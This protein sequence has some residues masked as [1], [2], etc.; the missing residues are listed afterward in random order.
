[1][2]NPI[3]KIEALFNDLVSKHV[4]LKETQADWL[5]KFH[6]LVPTFFKVITKDSLKHRG[7]EHKGYYWGKDITKDI[8]LQLMEDNDFFKVY[9]WFDSDKDNS[10]VVPLCRLNNLGELM[11]L[12][13]LIK[14]WE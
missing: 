1:M 2:L 7:Y 11:Q 10:E 13:S 12:E 4:K 8:S 9:V 5:L 3:L 6:E 14:T